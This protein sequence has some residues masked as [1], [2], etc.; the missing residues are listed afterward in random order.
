MNN[1]RKINLEMQN[2]YQLD[3]K[4]RSVFYNSRMYT[5]GYEHGT[6]YGDMEICIQV[7]ILNFNYLK[8]PGFHHKIL[9]QDEKT[10]EVYSDKFVIH[11]IELKKLKETPEEERGDL[12][13]WAEL[14]AAKNWEMV[15]MAVKGNSYMEEAKH[16]MDK[17]NQSEMERYLYLRR[18]M[19]YTDEVSRL[20]TAREEGER[21]KLC[22]LVMK[23][24]KKGNTA[25]EIADIFEEE[26]S[27]I[28]EVIKE[29]AEQK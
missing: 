21:N 3:W 2:R 20:R 12:Y 6:P 7:G 1:N 17:I 28:E 10:G 27:V 9:L 16:E 13:H 18:S 15:S 11:V 22:E 5:E 4:E 19:A 29:I 23:R 26:I 8:S 14:I 24:L 25:E